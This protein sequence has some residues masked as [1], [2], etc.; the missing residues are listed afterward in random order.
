MKE[1]IEMADRLE[2][3]LESVKLSEICGGIHDFD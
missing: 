2:A 3:E 1:H